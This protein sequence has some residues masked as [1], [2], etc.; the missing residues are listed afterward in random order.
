MLSSI[1]L[2]LVLQVLW[3]RSSYHKAF[4]DFHKETNMLFRNT[5]MAMRD[6]IVQRSMVTLPGDSVHGKNGRFHSLDSVL[7]RKDFPDSLMERFDRHERTSFIK[8]LVGP[9]SSDSLNQ[10][11]KP[12][13]SRFYNNSH[14]QGNFIFRLGPDSLNTDSIHYHF[15]TALSNAGL[16]LP[17]QVVQLKRGEKLPFHK[18]LLFSDL[19]R[20]NSGNRYAASFSGINSLLLKEIIPQVLFSA[21]LTILTIG[22]F[23]MMYRSVLTQQQMAELKNDFINN[24]T[25]E[26]KTPITTVRVALEALQDFKGLDNPQLTREYLDIAQNELSRLTLLT[27]KILRTAVFEKNGVVFQPE[28]VDLE[29]LVEQILASMKP[30]FDKS[31]AAVTFAKEGSDFILSGSV[32]HLTNVF[33]N[34]LDNA[35]KYSTSPPEIK[36]VVKGGT[37]NM[38]LSVRD[39]GQGIASEY[40]KKVFEKFF[41]VP[42]GDVHNVK[43]Y[44]LGLSYVDSVVR[45]HHGTLH[46][47][48]EP[49][50]GSCF[51][52]TLP[53]NE[54]N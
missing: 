16:D 51:I 9:D 6:S 17:F 39:N 33:Y 45:S 5:V 22:S 8:V 28:K 42:T 3:V 38:L 7:I 43:G 52:I 21:F 41:R 15:R 53:K 32:E 46:L 36:V 18:S 12:L 49:G 50:K 11:I 10:S 29:K 35:L 19:V 20:T 30:V 23:Y 13:V 37:D 26:L 47:E 34:L 48:S 2:L 4:D 44:G 14:R 1:L 40:H 24:V 27:D 54:K 25:H 31:G